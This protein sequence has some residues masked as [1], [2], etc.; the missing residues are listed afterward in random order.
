MSAAARA[1]WSNGWGALRPIF[2]G[3]CARLTSVRVTFSC[4]VCEVEGMR[5]MA[6]EYSGVEREY[7]G[8][9][10]RDHRRDAQKKRACVPRVARE[11]DRKRWGGGGTSRCTTE[12]K[13]NGFFP[14][15][16]GNNPKLVSTYI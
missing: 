5:D 12:L 8:R 4:G 15:M 10:R 16:D 13:V 11:S 14:N 9:I 6:G 1:D 7:P 3:R 2:P